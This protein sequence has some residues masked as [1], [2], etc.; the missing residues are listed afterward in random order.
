MTSLSLAL[1]S[2]M[3]MDFKQ[4][5]AKWEKGERRKI[6]SILIT[7]Y[8]LVLCHGLGQLGA[9]WGFSLL[10]PSGTGL[11]FPGEGTVPREWTD[12]CL[13]GRGTEKHN[14]G[15]PVTI[16]SVQFNLI[17]DLGGREFL[18]DSKNPVCDRGVV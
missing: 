11:P 4:N 14:S 6:Q 16:M 2:L 7:H 12:G 3:D 17:Q 8:F 10:L 9:R 18:R 15:L 1:F 5:K 13:E